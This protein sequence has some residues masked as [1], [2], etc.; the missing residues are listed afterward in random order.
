M[1]YCSGCSHSPL[2]LLATWGS[3]TEIAVIRA[4]WKQAIKAQT[5]SPRGEMNH[6]RV[7]ITE[8]KRHVIILLWKVSNQLKR[9]KSKW[10][11]YL[12]VGGKQAEDWQRDGHD[13]IGSERAPLC[14][15]H[16]HWQSAHRHSSAHP[17]TR[18]WCAGVFFWAKCSHVRYASGAHLCCL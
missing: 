16:I 4:D 5:V 13:C 15:I 10:W 12:Y 2:Q 17:G 9:Y 3:V 14:V 1:L 7:N 18:C 11:M 8:L 6:K